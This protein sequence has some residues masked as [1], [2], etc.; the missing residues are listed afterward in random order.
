MRVAFPLLCI[1]RRDRTHVRASIEARREAGDESTYR[2]TGDRQPESERDRRTGTDAAARE[3]AAALST[4]LETTTALAASAVVQIF[5]TSY[6]PAAGLVPR[7]ADLVTTERA[8]GSGVIVD[9]EGYIV[10]N[11]YVVRGA[12]RLRV[13][14]PV[15]VAGQSIL[16]RDTRE[17]SA[18]VV[19]IDVETDLAVVRIGER[20]LTALTFGDSDALKAGQVVL[21]LGSPL[22]LHNSVS[23][24]VVSAVARQLEP[25]SPMIYVQSDA[26]IVSTVPGAIDSR[27]GGLAP[28]DIVYA[29]NR[30]PVSGLDELRTAIDAL[31]AGDAVVLQ[32]ERD[33]ELLYL[34]F[35]IE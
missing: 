28:G 31:A 15:A 22:G 33:G 2:C 16:A 20:N 32:L 5:T 35:A 18:E 8:S 30:T 11:P 3:P 1:A 27:D 9:P 17:V 14:I 25:E 23:L 19:G 7:T 4:A 24:G 29:V 26:V 13:A 21:A 10:T 6:M 34:A 12:Q